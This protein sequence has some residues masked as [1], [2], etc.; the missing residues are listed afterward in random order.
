MAVPKTPVRSSLRSGSALLAE[1]QN[2]IGAVKT[3]HRSYL[4]EPI[5]GDFADSLDLDESLR[6]AHPGENRW[7]YLLGH[8]AN[9]TVVALEP[10]SARE[11]Q[12]TTIIRKRE[13]AKQQLAGHLKPT[14]RISKWLWVASGEVQLADTE[15]ARRRRRSPSRGGG[16]SNAT[17]ACTI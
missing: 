12:F 13:A 6:D 10:H 15:K 1:V 9:N 11:D 8:G 4:D 7:D 2:G 3:A 17:R 14:A 16:S 5:R